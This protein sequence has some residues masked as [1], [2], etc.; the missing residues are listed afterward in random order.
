M[1]GLRIV[2]KYSG[3]AINLIESMGESA[4]ILRQNKNYSE[5]EEL[6]LVYDEIIQRIRQVGH[7]A[8]KKDPEEVSSIVKAIL[9]DLNEPEFKTRYQV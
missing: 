9:T 2:E 7:H 1:L 8:H 6:K 5:D 4:K 3:P